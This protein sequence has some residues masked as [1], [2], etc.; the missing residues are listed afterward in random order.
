MAPFL[1]PSISGNDSDESVEKPVTSLTPLPSVPPPDEL[2]AVTD[3]DGP[4]DPANPKNWSLGLRIYHTML[5]AL[6]G[7][8]V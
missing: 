7:F 2:D 8:S 3:W 5:P 1:T 4:A 6:Y